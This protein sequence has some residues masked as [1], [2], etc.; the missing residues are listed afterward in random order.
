VTL[1]TASSPED[2]EIRV[3]EAQPLV[4]DSGLIENELF[5]YGPNG[6]PAQAL[7]SPTWQ[8]AWEAFKRGEQLALPHADARP[9]DPQKQARLTEAYAR[10]RAGALSADE[11]P[12]LSDI[13]PDDPHTRAQLGLQT[14]PDA[15]PPDALIQACGSCHNDV[16]DQTLSRARFNIA[17]ARM[18]RAEL[19]TAID[20]IGRD[21][22]AP[23]VMPPPDARQLDQDVRTQLLDYL[24][25]SAWPNDDIA[26]LDHAARLGMAGGGRR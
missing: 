5:P 22:S 13:F 14:E 2:L 21:R 4:F 3:G 6:Y 15:T 17:I 10:Y 18:D 25:R 12:D 9:T 1:V 7:P 16:L 8:A 19:D 11:L 24:R 20:R 23:G 26:R